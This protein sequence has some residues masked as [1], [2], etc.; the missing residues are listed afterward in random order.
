MGAD[1]R[2][3]PRAAGGGARARRIDHVGI[4]VADVQAAARW[5]TDRLGLELVHVADVLDS[6]VRLAYLD[7]GDTTLQLVQPLRAGPVAD[8]LAAHGE[9]LHH[10]CFLVDDIDVALDGLGDTGRR[11]VYLGGRGADVCFIGDT[12]CA[13]LVELTEATDPAWRPGG[14]R[15]VL[16]R[17]PP[18]GPTAT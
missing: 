11:Q 14:R 9:G 12:P 15:P 10:L 3:P 6:S 5:W 2:Q 13:V 8:W 17:E 7:I 16:V 18:R 1:I 4:V